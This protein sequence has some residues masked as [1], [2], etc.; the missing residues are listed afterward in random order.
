MEEFVDRSDFPATENCAYLNAASIALMPKVAGET[1][2][3][4]N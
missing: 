4:W 1:I 2:V 3:E